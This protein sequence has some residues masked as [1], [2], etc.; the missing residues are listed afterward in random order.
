ME[1]V[2][3]MVMLWILFAGTHIGLAA[4]PVRSTLVARTGERGFSVLFSVVAAVS[5]TILVTFYAAHR[6][7]GLPGF[8]V[9]AL[10]PVRWGL[11]ALM[12]AAS[13]LLAASLTAYPRSPYALLSGRGI[14]EPR[15]LER[16]TRHG[17]FAATAVFAVVHALLA[18]RLVGTIFAGGFAVLAIV[19]AWH[20]DRKF[21]ARHGET[22]AAYLAV[23]STLPF[24]AIV[25]GRQRL[26]VSE[27]PLRALGLGAAIAVVLRLGHDYLFAWGG[28]LIVAVVVG[29]AAV[30]TVQ[31]WRRGRRP[32]APP[33][34]AAGAASETPA[35]RSSSWEMADVGTRTRL[36]DAGGR[37]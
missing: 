24:G 15:G 28:L 18:T 37:S 13:A 9:G 36:D 6:F 14:R 33:L 2:V 30:E 3:S 32:P 25:A 1:S 11:M 10:A 26:V 34:P 21:L 5:F 27:L 29:G 35:A 20:Q 23:T 8:A 17:F 12:V 22:Y 7:E 31:A 16:I 4:R 19:G